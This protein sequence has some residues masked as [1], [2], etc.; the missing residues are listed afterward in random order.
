MPHRCSPGLCGSS[1]RAGIPPRILYWAPLRRQDEG[2]HTRHHRSAA[3]C[4][5]H[6]FRGRAQRTSFQV[7]LG[8]PCRLEYSRKRGSRPF[9]AD[10]TRAKSGR[11]VWSKRPPRRRWK[12][13]L[14]ATAVESVEFFNKGKRTN[15]AARTTRL[16]GK[17]GMRSGRSHT[18]LCS[19]LVYRA[20]GQSTKQTPSQTSTPFSALSA[21]KP[22]RRLATEGTLSALLPSAHEKNKHQTFGCT[23]RSNTA[24][25]VCEF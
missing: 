21:R 3:P 6:G 13:P 9:G 7:V 23:G 16:W 25:G 17:S 15:R 20:G 8:G 14:E 2:P 11:R 5:L 12:L 10:D 1:R 19:V 18:C 24:S 4:G 22:R